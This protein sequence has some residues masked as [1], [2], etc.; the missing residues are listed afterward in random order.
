MIDKFLDE[1]VRRKKGRYSGGDKDG[2]KRGR[3]GKREI[4]S[5]R[6]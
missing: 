2:G 1:Q 5:V 3:R 4:Q 6:Y